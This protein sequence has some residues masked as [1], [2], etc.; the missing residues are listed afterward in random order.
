MFVS[1][2]VNW[3]VEGILIRER[4][5]NV[6]WRFV[7]EDWYSLRRLVFFGDSDLIEF[8]FCRGLLFV[9]WIL[10]EVGFL[11]VCDRIFFLK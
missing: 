10:K 4:K 7:N 8:V 9:I 1:K 3:K 5:I 11:F 6:N 2:G